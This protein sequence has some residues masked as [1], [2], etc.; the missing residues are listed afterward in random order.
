M[1]IQDW[2]MIVAVLS[3]PLIAVQL[4]RY[5]DNKKEIR[6]RKLQ[7]FK[8]LMASRANNISMYHVE[9]L[10]RIDLEFNSNSKS[11]KNVISAWKEYHDLLANKE[12]SPEQWNI[13][14]IDL[15]VELLFK[16]SL[17]LGYEFDK[18]HIKNSAY[19]PM[20]H[21]NIENQLSDIREGFVE[22]LDG[23]RSLPI[24][25]IRSPSPQVEEKS[26]I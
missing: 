25:I 11:E 21:G 5:L 23:K 18:I 1:N 3:G 26:E 7:I 4:T 6:D 8:T 17:V 15:L 22:I 20:A 16:M 12:L 9:A 2:V 10:N 24:Q 13:K 14:R 19:S